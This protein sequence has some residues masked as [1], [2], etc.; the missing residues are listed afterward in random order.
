M[1]ASQSSACGPGAVGGYGKWSLKNRNRESNM[2]DIK[3]INGFAALYEQLS[4]PDR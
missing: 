4:P 1:L 2:T 3:T